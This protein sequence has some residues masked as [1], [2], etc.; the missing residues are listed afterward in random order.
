MAKGASVLCALP[1]RS[2]D[3]DAPRALSGE[4]IEVDFDYRN[5]KASERGAAAPGSL[6][7]RLG[8]AE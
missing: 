2:H 7:A 6:L 5:D 3:T 8:G 4:P 1:A